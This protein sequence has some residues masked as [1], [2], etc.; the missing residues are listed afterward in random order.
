MNNFQETL[1]FPVRDAESRKQFLIACALM[2]AGFVIPILPVILLMGYTTKIMRQIIHEKQAASMP[3]WQG[4]DWSEMFM[5]GL[6]LYSAQLVLSLPLLILMGCGMISIFA[7]SAGFAA[8]ADERSQSLAPVGGLFLVLGMAIFSVFSILALPYGVILSAAQAH[9]AAKRSFQAA[10]E[11]REWWSI[12]RKAIGQFIVAYAIIIVTSFIFAFVLQVAMFT[13][14]L[15]CI[16][17]FLMIPYSAYLMLVT[18]TV[19]A[20]AYASGQEGIQPA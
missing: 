7:G 15:I 6:R 2:L 14:V 9:V 1:L 10:F 19:Y 5:D 11:F 13:I 18:N 8:L 12:F 3:A 4:S 17:P 20:Q 16:I